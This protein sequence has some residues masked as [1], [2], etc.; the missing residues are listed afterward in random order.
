M[1]A[2]PGCAQGLP[3][4]LIWR[5]QINI[6]HIQFARDLWPFSH[7]FIAGERTPYILSIYFIDGGPH[8]K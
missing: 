2:H 4:P 8:I 6:G 3:A 1:E 5:G 7:Y